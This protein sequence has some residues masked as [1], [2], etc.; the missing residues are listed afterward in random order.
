MLEAR[1]CGKCM[2]QNGVRGLTRKLCDEADTAGVLV[3][4]RV[5]Q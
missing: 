3:E 1:K 4:T 2:I 5:D